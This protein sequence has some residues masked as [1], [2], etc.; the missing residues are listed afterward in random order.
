MKVNAISESTDRGIHVTTH[1]ELV[2]L[3]NGA[4]LIDNPGMREVGITNTTGGLE[5]TF[6]KIYEL[7]EQCKFSDCTHTSEKGCAVLD[8]LASGE[9]DEDVLENFYKME[10]EQAY[11]ASTVL[12]RKNK[13]KNLGKMIREVKDFQ[14]KNRF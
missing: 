2:P 5:V 9:L 13:Y 1:R 4:L 8:A 14:K 6:E 7:A 10:S 11:F 3:A 12:E